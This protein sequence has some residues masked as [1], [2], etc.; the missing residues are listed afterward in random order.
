MVF[1]KLAACVSSVGPLSLVLNEVGWNLFVIMF[2]YSELSEGLTQDD[3]FLFCLPWS[4]LGIEKQRAFLENIASKL[5][6]CSR[7]FKKKINKK[8]PA[9]AWG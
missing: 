7:L 6:T 5:K 1:L 8:K 4:S 3:S 9:A 2:D